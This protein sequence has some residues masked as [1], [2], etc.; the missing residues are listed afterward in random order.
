MAD[1]A[2]K[3]GPSVLKN[4]LAEITSGDRQKIRTASAAAAGLLIR[5]VVRKVN[6]PLTPQQA[7]VTSLAIAV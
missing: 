2:T 3:N 5:R 7:S 1:V 4:M 6:H